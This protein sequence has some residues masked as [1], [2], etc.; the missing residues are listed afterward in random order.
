MA[1]LRSLENHITIDV[2]SILSNALLDQTLIGDG[3]RTTVATVYTNFYLD[4]LFKQAPAGNIYVSPRFVSLG[5]FVAVLQLLL[6]LLQLTRNIRLPPV[7][8][9]VRW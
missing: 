3:K 5:C 7:A 9:A 2:S 8:A 6:L 4:M 1:A